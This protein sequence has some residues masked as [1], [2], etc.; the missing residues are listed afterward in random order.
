M[1]E[2]GGFVYE[3]RPSRWEL[4]WADQRYVNGVMLDESEYDSEDIQAPDE[5]LRLLPFP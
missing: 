2:S 4:T 5:P 3:R 1:P